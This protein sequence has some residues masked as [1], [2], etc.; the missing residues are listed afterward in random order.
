MVKSRKIGFRIFKENCDGQAS[1]YH[2]NPDIIG[3]WVKSLRT[4]INQYGFHKYFKAIRRLG[5]GQFATVFEVENF[6]TGHK[7]AVKGFSKINLK[8]M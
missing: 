7:F 6:E 8:R 5:K 4:L 2:S 1:F 3:N